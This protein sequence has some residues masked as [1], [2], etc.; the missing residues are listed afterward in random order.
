MI[1]RSVLQEMLVP[2]AFHAIDK[3][4][5]HNFIRSRIDVS[6]KKGPFLA[7][8]HP[9]TPYRESVMEAKGM[10]NSKKLLN[11]LHQHGR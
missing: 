2:K 8:I 11:D 3:R 5:L 6:K 7:D 9:R 4:S 1:V 10:H